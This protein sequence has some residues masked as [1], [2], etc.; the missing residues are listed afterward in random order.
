MVQRMLERDA[1]ARKAK[2]KTRKP[3]EKKSS[4][5]DR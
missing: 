1:R 2:N 3:P 5:K 4:R